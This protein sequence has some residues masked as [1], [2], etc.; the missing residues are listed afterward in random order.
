MEKVCKKSTVKNIPISHFNFGKQPKTANTCDRLL[1]IKYYFK[2]DHE[3]AE[4]IPESKS[5]HAIF[6]KKSKK[7]LKKDKKG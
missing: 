2:G 1:G 6:Q 4:A 5:M 3:K 7:M